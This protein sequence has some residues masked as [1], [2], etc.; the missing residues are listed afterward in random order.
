MTGRGNLGNSS[1]GRGGSRGRGASKGGSRGGRGGAKNGSSSGGRP[2]GDTSNGNGKGKGKGKGKVSKGKKPKEKGPNANLI[3][4]GTPR[5]RKPNDDEGQNGPNQNQLNDLEGRIYDANEEAY[6]PPRLR[7]NPPNTAYSSGN[8]FGTLPMT[9]NNNLNQDTVGNNQNNTV[10]N[11]SE[12]TNN[13]QAGMAPAAAAAAAAASPSAMG[14]PVTAAPV[15]EPGPTQ[16]DAP[17]IMNPDLNWPA[18]LTKFYID[19]MARIGNLKKAK[20]LT[21]KQQLANII[22]MAVRRNVVDSNDWANQ[23]VPICSGGGKLELEIFRIKKKPKKSN[24]TEDDTNKKS[25]EKPLNTN[26]NSF[27]IDVNGDAPYDPTKKP[28]TSKILNNNSSSSNNNNNNKKTKGDNK[29]F[30]ETGNNFQKNENKKRQLQEEYD[31]EA[32]KRARSERFAQISEFKPISTYYE[33]QRRKDSGAVVGTSEQLEKSYFRLTSAPNPAQVRSLKVLHD[34]L[35]Y[36]V[37]KY[38]ESHNYSYIIDQ[39]KSIRQDL[40]VQHIK[41]EF[42]VHVYEKNARISIENNDLGEF[43]QCQAQ[44]KSL[45][46]RLRINKE[47]YKHRFILYEVEMMTYSFIYM[48]VTKNQSEINKFRL[49]YLKYKHFKK[50]EFEKP[51]FKLMSALFKSYLCTLQGDFEVFFKELEQFAHIKETKISFKFIND[52]LLGKVRL[53][54][55]YQIAYSYRRFLVVTASEKLRFPD[56]QSCLIYLGE[57]GLEK[58]L[59]KGNHEFDIPKTQVALKELIAKNHRVDIKGQI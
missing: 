16:V 8:N 4:L 46:H 54:S 56:P 18:P 48:I 28:T 45:Y 1:R 49:Q 32:R 12:S 34:S 51:Y 26:N 42:T 19:S 39:L 14:A 3:P 10:N 11:N 35:K 2:N 30:K 25:K 47:K 55:L 41:D 53:E 44:L 15:A 40:T 5:T 29:K 38:E 50:H 59:M 23:R 13:F 58:C 37:R 20:Q 31:S 24:S 17:I 22:D 6:V 57:L 43:N 33:D 36:V 52:H 21:G 27:Y 9:N 7:Q